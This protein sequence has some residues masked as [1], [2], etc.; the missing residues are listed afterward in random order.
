MSHVELIGIPFSNYVRSIRIVC[1]E[2]GVPYTLTAVMPHSPEV[3]AVHPSGL[4]PCFRHGDMS[5]FESKAI[6]TYIDRVFDGPKL[7]PDDPASAAKVEQWVS[8]CNTKVD[9]FIMRE[10]VV[11][12]LFANKETGPDMEKIN[13]A[14]VQIEDCCRVLD[15]AV[16][17][18]GHL[19]GDHLTYADCNVVPMLDALQNFPQGQEILAKLPA[20]SKYINTHTARTSF[21]ETEAAPPTS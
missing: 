16:K 14:L 20:L 6:A 4:V 3:D 21:K 7:I 19:V 9:R 2:K 17:P 15:A 1:E 11:P 8:Y 10:F 13:A 5:L 18:T 12:T